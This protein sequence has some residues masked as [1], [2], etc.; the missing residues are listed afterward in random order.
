MFLDVP[1]ESATPVL[2]NS[3]AKLRRAAG[4]TKVQPNT[5]NA[6]LSGPLSPFRA[7]STKVQPNTSNAVLSGPLSH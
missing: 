6:V 1:R 5:L 4:S 3:C 2:L 7:G